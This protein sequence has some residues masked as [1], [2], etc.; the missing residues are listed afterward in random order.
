M[1]LRF[2]KTPVVLF[3][4][5]GLITASSL[6]R[7]A[8]VVAGAVT[9]EL[10]AESTAIVPGERFNVALDFKLEAH[11]HIYWIN[12]GASGLPVEV[13]WDLPEGLSAGEIQ[14]PAPERI[15][16]GGLMNYGYED[17]V[18]LIVPIQAAEDLKIGTAM[19]IRAEVSWLVCEQFLYAGRCDPKPRADCWI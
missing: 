15:E 17:A 11:W 13:Q 12:P 8:P 6:L 16:L 4:L 14:W 1:M 10:I 3:A 9:V 7:A 5:F 19:P 18:T 2:I